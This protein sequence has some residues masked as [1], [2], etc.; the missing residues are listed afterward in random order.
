MPKTSLVFTAV[1][2]ALAIFGAAQAE[3][4]KGWMLS[5][6]K[7]QKYD[8]CRDTRAGKVAFIRGRPGEATVRGCGTLM[9]IVDAKPYLGKRLRLSTSLKADSAERA[10][11]WMCVDGRDRAVAFDNTTDRPLTGR[12]E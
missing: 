3:P 9:Q 1:L 2:A 4:P 12:T 7:P 5:G 8:R 10:Q 11:M 6:S